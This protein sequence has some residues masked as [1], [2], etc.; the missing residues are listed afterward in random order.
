MNR[1]MLFKESGYSE[2]SAPV[3]KAL[4]VVAENGFALSG[5]MFNDTELDWGSDFGASM[6]NAMDDDIIVF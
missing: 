2:Y 4:E 3:V 5:G 6:F 1:L